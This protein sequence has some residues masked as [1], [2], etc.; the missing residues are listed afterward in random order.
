MRPDLLDNNGDSISRF[1]LVDLQPGREADYVTMF[2]MPVPK[3]TEPN[4]N[5]R[6]SVNLPLKRS[7][8]PKEL[9]E[10]ATKMD[11]NKL[12]EGSEGKELFATE[13][14]IIANGSTDYIMPNKDLLK[15]SL[16]KIFDRPRNM[17]KDPK[18]R[19][20]VGSYIYERLAR[21]GLVVTIHDFKHEIPLGEFAKTKGMLVEA[22]V[23]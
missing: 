2:F 10:V 12:Q 9:L 20:I 13:E 14:Q 16:L 17:W 22:L 4:L 11:F 5:L 23:F 21:S 18:S 8:L 1:P 3:V 19:E 15:F 7:D 6:Y